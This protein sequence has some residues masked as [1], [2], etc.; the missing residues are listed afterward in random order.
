[1][2]Q[3]SPAAHAI[4]AAIR[5]L[6]P[7]TQVIDRGA[8]LRVLVPERC[9]VTRQAI[10][11]A[12]GAQFRLPGDLEAVMSSFKGRFTVSEDQAAWE[13]RPREGR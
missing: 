1:V 12:A 8:Y 6:N 5:A 2:L 7:Q 11:Q 10:E 3:A 13:Y 9:V 4:V